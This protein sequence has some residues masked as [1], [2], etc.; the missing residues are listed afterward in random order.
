VLAS[1]LLMLVVAAFLG[2]FHSVEKS[3]AYVGGRSES[4]DDMRVTMARMTRDIRQGVGVVGIATTRHLR[5]S[6]YVDGAAQE[7]TYDVTGTTLTR[8]VGSGNAVVLQNGLGSTSVF[9]YSPS[10]TSPQVVTVTLTV[11]PPGAPDTTVTIDS[12][13]QLRNLG[14]S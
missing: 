6:T 14:G 12:E 3:E 10:T 11:V 2:A 1:A 5:L 13:V 7:V 9:Q 8:K 4:L